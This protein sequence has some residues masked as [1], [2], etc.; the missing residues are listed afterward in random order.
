MFSFHFLLKSSLPTDFSSGLSTTN[1]PLPG[2]Y[3][4]PAL[5]WKPNP[6]TKQRLHPWGFQSVCFPLAVN[7]WKGR[8]GPNYL[9][10]MAP[11]LLLATCSYLPD[12]A[13]FPHSL[14]DLS[15]QTQSL[16]F[17]WVRTC[18]SADPPTLLHPVTSVT[19][20]PGFWPHHSPCTHVFLVLY[21]PVLALIPG[22]STCCHPRHSMMECL[23][24][25]YLPLET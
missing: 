23:T 11:F 18:T 13:W 16:Y 15:H 24:Q 25:Q 20:E 12:L 22:P 5:A 9:S 19:W 4:F 7:G 14:P 2:F 6:V 10:A 1:M 17:Q 21:S 3:L 8:E